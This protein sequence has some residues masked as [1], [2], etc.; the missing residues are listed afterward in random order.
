MIDPPKHIQG[1]KVVRAVR[2]LPRQGEKPF[3]YL[4]IVDRGDEYSEYGQFVVMGAVSTDGDIWDG[5]T[6]HYVLT[7]E[8]AGVIFD[9]RKE[10]LG[11]RVVNE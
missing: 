5:H 8:R 10:E 6:G 2:I 4:V 7:A 1:W 3:Q 11:Y 9:E